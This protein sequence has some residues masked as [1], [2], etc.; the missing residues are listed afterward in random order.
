MAA[1]AVILIAAIA[2]GVIAVS[3]SLHQPPVPAAP[4]WTP[5][6]PI[7]GIPNIAN[8]PGNP[9]PLPAALPAGMNHECGI[10]IGS[11][12]T[13]AALAAFFKDALT[14]AGWSVNTDGQIQG[15]VVTTWT[16]DPKA[17]GGPQ[18]GYKPAFTGLTGDDVASADAVLDANGTSWVVNVH[19]TPRGAA[20]FADLTRANVAACP[21]DAST[22]QSATCAQ[23]FLAMWV[24]LT[25]DDIDHWEDPAYANGVSAPF[26]GAGG[27]QN[28]YPTLIE[29]AITL[30]PITGG[31]FQLTA[32]TRESAD[33]LAEGFNTRLFG[34]H[35]QLTFTKGGSFGVIDLVPA[36]NVTAIWVRT[37]S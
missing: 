9:S 15:F 18:P 11:T 5:C 14:N 33:Y 35:V 6:G 4:R 36:G 27:P 22:S 13:P 16:P 17:T 8:G 3:R 12:E 32:S 25:Q 19:L 1:T 21:G 28:T 37:V 10:Y 30:M 29:D 34:T 23:R 20:L 2:V 26:D 7:A 31:E 24:R